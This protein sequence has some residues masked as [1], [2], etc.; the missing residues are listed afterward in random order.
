MEFDVRVLTA[1]DMERWKVVEQTAFMGTQ[2][3]IDREAALYN[4]DWVL[5]A[6]VD[7]ELQACTSSIPF[8]LCLEGAKV[9]MGGVSGV[10]T[11]PGYRRQGLVSALLQRTL[12][13]SREH[14]EPLSGLWTPHPALYRRYGWELSSDATMSTFSPKLALEPGPRSEGRIEALTAEGWR[15]AAAVY[16]AWA[17]NRNSCLTRTEVM[18]SQIILHTRNRASYVYRNRDGKAEGYV[19]LN[20]PSGGRMADRTLTVQWLAALTAPAHRALLDLVL[21]H[22]LVGNIRWVMPPD[23]P[24][25]DLV[26]DPTQIEM[27]RLTAYGL[28]LRVVDFQA[29]VAA[30]PTYGEGKLT[31]RIEDRDCPW[32]A[33]DWSVTA[34]GGRLFAEPTSEAPMLSVSA[35]ALAQLYNGFRSPSTLALA[36]RLDVRDPAALPV[37][38]A[39]FAM[40]NVPFCP[41]EF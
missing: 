8:E 14:G 26:Q 3:E 1:G 41:D 39:L 25:I 19:V 32:N 22:D 21:S 5:G 31:L 12:E 4:P 2:E 40:R 35:R 24:F 36:G 37:A 7:G 34:D 29:A 16:E 10:A 11:M 20:V 30:R 28:M 9:P 6:F 18:W 13:R 38:D 33:A 17:K 23:E 15:E 27:V